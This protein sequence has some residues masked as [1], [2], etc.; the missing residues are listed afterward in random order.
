MA[1]PADQKSIDLPDLQRRTVQ[2]ARSEA[3][4]PMKSEPGIFD[5]LGEADRQQAAA[6]SANIPDWTAPGMMRPFA[7]E[8]QKDAENENSP[9][10][11]ALTRD[12]RIAL[13]VPQAF[14]V[15]SSLGGGVPGWINSARAGGAP[16]AAST[17]RA[18]SAIGRQP[19]DWT[20]PSP[21]LDTLYPGPT[22]ISQPS[23]PFSLATMAGTPRLTP[24]APGPMQPATTPSEAANRRRTLF[25]AVD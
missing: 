3:A 21:T 14:L 18:F 22:P 4:I 1:P 19:T 15:G 12:A 2:Q 11:N 23:Q 5:R 6:I 16:A 25:P 20:Q 24:F 9:L 17:N 13:N 7:T 8:A 10:M